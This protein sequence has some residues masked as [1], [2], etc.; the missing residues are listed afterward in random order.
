[1][2]RSVSDVL[3]LA[4]SLPPSSLT[5]RRAPPRPATAEDRLAVVARLH[6]PFLTRLAR[7]LCRSADL[8][9]DLVQDALVRTVAAW[10]RLP[11]DVN[12]AAWMARTLRNLFIDR[13]RVARAPTVPL[14]A[15]DCPTPGDAD[16]VAWWEHLTA[17]DVRAAARRLSPEFRVAFERH[18]FDGRSY[19][20]IAAELGVPVATVGTRILRAR[21]QLCRALG[22]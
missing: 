9:D 4:L 18:A 10:D 13:L 16:E 8:A 2:V 15:D 19:K 14:D 5:A 11:A 21:R 6:R 1:M 20:Q 22:G 7:R 12:H 17:A 3:A